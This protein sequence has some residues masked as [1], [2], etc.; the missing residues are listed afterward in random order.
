MTVELRRLI[1]L[2]CC[3]V[4]GVAVTRLL[5]FDLRFQTVLFPMF[6]AA[7]LLAAALDRWVVK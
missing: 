3:M 4:L 1:L 7:G 2:V 6:A 5:G